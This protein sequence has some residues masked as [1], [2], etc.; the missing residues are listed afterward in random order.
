MA[1]TVNIEGLSRY[2]KSWNNTLKELPF[3]TFN[4]AA[5]ELRLNIIK[6]QGED[7]AVTLRRKAGIVKPYYPG[8]TAGNQQEILNFFEQK[9]KPE[10][11]YAEINDNVTNYRDKKVISNQ[12]E[13]FNNKTKK[14]PL[15]A[16][17]LMA[18]VRS[19]AEDVVFSMFFA[20]R[21]INVPSPMTAFNGFF[22]KFGLLQVAGE[23][24]AAK[25]NLKTTGSFDAGV[26]VGVGGDG[27]NHYQRL[28]DFVKSSHPL[29]RRGEVI[30]MCTE[31]PLAA[32]RDGL[33]IKMNYFAMPT[34]EEMLVKLRSDA[35][36]PNLTICTHECLGTG[37][38]LVLLKP[39]LLDI[40]VGDNTDKDFVQVRNPWGDPN[41]VQFWMQASYDT[42]LVDCHAKIFQTNEQ[43]NIALDLAGDYPAPTSGGGGGTEPEPEEP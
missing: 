3:Y 12:G 30:L 26:N 5:L 15:E 24:S 18:K 32:A 11:T 34:V 14:H 20:E 22:T 6:V 42:R 36:C 25:N 29:L 2:A 21:D 16:L 31:L 13:W 8:I 33:R 39:G 10:I 17:I 1:D 41:I 35:N 27:I 19:Y 9:L 37:S 4:E 38:K 7:I 23:I 40:G 43:N 28:V